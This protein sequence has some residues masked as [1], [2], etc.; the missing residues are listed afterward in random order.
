[1]SELVPEGYYRDH[2]GNLHKDRRDTKQDRRAVSGT[3]TNDGDRRNRMRRQSDLEN[4]DRE[5]HTMIE[6]ALE[7][8]AANH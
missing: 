2:H 5:H 4:L 8:F 6:D 7:D 1:M 3:D